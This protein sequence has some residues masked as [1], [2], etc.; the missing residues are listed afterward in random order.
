MVEEGELEFIFV[1]D[2]FEVFIKSVIKI[3]SV[4]GYMSLK[5]GIYVR[6]GDMN[7]KVIIKWMMVFEVF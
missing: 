4:S 1:F 3:L 5:Y 2:M 6:I 7:W